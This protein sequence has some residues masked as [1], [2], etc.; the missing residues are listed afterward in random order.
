MKL[1]FFATLIS[2]PALIGLAAAGV[3]IYKNLAEPEKAK[4]DTVSEKT[5]LAIERPETTVQEEQEIA[6]ETLLNK[7][8]FNII[9]PAGWQEVS[10]FP[11]VL[12]MAIDSKEKLK[13]EKTKNLDFITNF[14]IKNDDLSKYTR[15]FTVEDYGKSIEESLVQLI[16]GIK[17]TPEKLG[18]I[19]GQNAFFVETESTQEEVDFKT[20]LVFIEGNNNTIWAISFNTFKDSWLAYKDLFYQIAESFKLKYKLEF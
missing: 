13:E 7:D 3:F 17:F 10:D 8:G 20:L 4:E 14:S 18:A 1:K 6:K 12:A 5:P 16:P 9:L 15:V 19:N 2:L 11:D